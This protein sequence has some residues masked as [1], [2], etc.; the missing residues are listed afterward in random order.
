MAFGSGIAN[1]TA[2]AIAT[3]THMPP[4]TVLTIAFDTS[5]LKRLLKKAAQLQRNKN[6]VIT[7]S[8]R[9]GMRVVAKQIKKDLPAYT[10]RVIARRRM[11]S[12]GRAIAGQSKLKEAK[13]AIGTLARISKGGRGPVPAREP[14]AK[15]G[16][17][18]GLPKRTSADRPRGGRKG[19]GRGNLHWYLMGTAPRMTQGGV[20]TGKMRRTMV[21][22]R[23]WAVTRGLALAKMKRNLAAGIQREAARP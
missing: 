10:T 1:A 5:S 21:V 23:A 9:A 19:M 14:E 18:V 15:V 4:G 13:K 16:S 6:R 20:Y 3:Q 22:S 7:A 11:A 8:M 2:W 12:P 17:N